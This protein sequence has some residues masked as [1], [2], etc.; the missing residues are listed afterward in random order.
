MLKIEHLVAPWSMWCHNLALYETIKYYDVTVYHH[1]HHHGGMMQHC[2]DYKAPGGKWSIVME[3]RH[4]DNIIYH[5][6]GTVK[7]SDHTVGCVVAQ[8]NPLRI[9]YSMMMSWFSITA[10]EWD[11]MMPHCKS[12]KEPCEHSVALWHHNQLWVMDTAF[13]V[14]RCVHISPSFFSILL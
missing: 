14:L 10:E 7:H 11:N 1:H 13:T 6:N 5:F 9:H 4:C 8:S 12:T 2:D 3:Q